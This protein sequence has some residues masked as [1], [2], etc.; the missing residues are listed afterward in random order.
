MGAAHVQTRS[1]ERVRTE[2]SLHVLDYN[3]KRVILIL[4][5]QPPMAAMRA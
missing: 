1:L 4:G 3:L 2:F 5:T